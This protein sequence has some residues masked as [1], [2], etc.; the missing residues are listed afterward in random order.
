MS[1]VEVKYTAPSL[2]KVLKDNAPNLSK[3]DIQTHMC[4]QQIMKKFPLPNLQP[5]AEQQKMAIWDF[6]PPSMNLSSI[7]P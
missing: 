6:F 4:K 7:S 3:P 1:I 5:V 2:H